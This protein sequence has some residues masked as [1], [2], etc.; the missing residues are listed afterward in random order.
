MLLLQRLS[1]LKTECSGGLFGLMY[2]GNLVVLGFNLESDTKAGL[3]YKKM[4]E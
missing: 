4:Q 3:N 2:Q 1:N